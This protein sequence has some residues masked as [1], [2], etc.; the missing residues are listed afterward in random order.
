MV[1]THV[2]TTTTAT[3]TS[4]PRMTR[5]LLSPPRTDILPAF[6]LLRPAMNV[7]TVRVLVTF[8]MTDGYVVCLSAPKVT[9]ERDKGIFASSPAAWGATTGLGADVVPSR[10]RFSSGTE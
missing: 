5:R 7:R 1:G 3:T 2:S 10:G 9:L 8:M 6:V 4:M